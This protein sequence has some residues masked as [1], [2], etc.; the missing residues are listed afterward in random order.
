MMNSQISNEQLFSEVMFGLKEGRII[1]EAISAVS[2]KYNLNFG[3]TKS[4]WYKM[5]KNEPFSNHYQI[6]L[7]S[8]SAL[9]LN[10]T[11]PYQSDTTAEK[12]SDFS[13]R[14]H[15]TLLNLYINNFNNFYQLIK[16]KPDLLSKLIV[17]QEHQ[18]EINN[19]QS[20]LVKYE[21]VYQ[22]AKQMEA[23]VK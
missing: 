4:R 23:A 14:E 9:S 12:M 15:E 22:L 17:V 8:Q 2:E 5:I 18:K 16:D 21:K 6:Y 7:E 3:S 1:T 10:E 20:Q 11:L 13:V 19:Y